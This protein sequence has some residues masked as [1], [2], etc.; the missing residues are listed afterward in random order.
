MLQNDFM[1]HPGE[2]LEGRQLHSGLAADPEDLQHRLE[3]RDSEDTHL[4]IARRRRQ[5]QGRPRHDAQ[6]SF[7]ADKQLAQV[8]SGVVLT[9]PRV[10]IEHFATGQDDLDTKH[11]F[12][13][14]AKPDKLHASGIGGD[15]AADL[16]TALRSQ[17]ER[18]KQ[19]HLLC[20]FLDLLRRDARLDANGL[21]DLVQLLDLRHAA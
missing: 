1:R 9:Q 17:V 6:G 4:H 11:L 8:I 2:K 5:T 10:H 14:A 13:H 18:E 7:G 15:I 20:R 3:A 12:A 16:A 19:A 21:T